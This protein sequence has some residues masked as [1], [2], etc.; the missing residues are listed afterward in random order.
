MILV[1]G[2]SGIVGHSVAETLVNSGHKVRAL[3][4]KNSNI[5]RLSHIQD[6]IEWFESDVL[7]IASLSKA[8]D[9]IERVVH[10][11]A[12]VSFH[13]EDKDK[14]M[15]I[16][17]EGTSNMLN[18]ALEYGI[19]KFVHVSSV[20]ALGRKTND[21]FIDERVKWE[22]SE[23]NSN[24]G[25]SKHQAELEVWRAQEEGLSTVIVN[26]SV[27]L[28]PGDWNSSSMQIF[29]YINENRLFY[30]PGE[31]NYVDVRDVI[32]AINL[33][34]FN[35]VES[36]RFIINS[37]KASYKE[38]FNIIAKHLNKSAPRI[39]VTKALL[40]FAYVLDTVKS[41]LLRQRS[42]I[43]KETTRISKQSYL[44]SSEK[45]KETLG[46]NFK[47]LEESISWTCEEIRKQP[48]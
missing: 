34:L 17:V 1:T 33:L 27:I 4:R 29:K 25:E 18:L 23:N 28:G 21:L 32:N 24:Y 42:V 10:C 35:E 40:T 16:N 22:E 47:T 8:F 31:M 30:P 13:K 20:A 12:L 6:K 9:G 15:Q 2:A 19:K 37:G 36:E 43:T 41:K 39:K 38:T 46:V 7:D 26:P 14:M 45:I 48:I 11:A 3:K 5:S 44:Y